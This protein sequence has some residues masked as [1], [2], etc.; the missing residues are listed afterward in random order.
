MNAWMTG[1][2]VV[3]S[4]VLPS[5]ATRASEFEQPELGVGGGRVVILAG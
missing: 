2:I 1:S 5:N 3:V 4:A